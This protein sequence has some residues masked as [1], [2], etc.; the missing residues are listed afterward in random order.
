MTLT[1]L[2]KNGKHTK[3][4]TDSEGRKLS[5]PR[6][7]PLLLIQVKST[8]LPNTLYRFINYPHHFQ[9]LE[10]TTFFLGTSIQSKRENKRKRVCAYY[11][12]GPVTGAET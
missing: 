5:L 9:T 4:C 7:L 3:S 8:L 6:K 10:I 12:P 11:T 2:W 1:H